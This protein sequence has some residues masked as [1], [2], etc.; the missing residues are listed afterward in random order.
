METGLVTVGSGAGAVALANL[1]QY[2]TDAAGAYSAA[3][4]RALAKGSA[5][6]TSWCQENGRAFLPAPPGTVVAYLEAAAERYATATVELYAWAIGRLHEAAG[7]ENPCKAERVR[8]RLRAIRRAKGTRGRQAVG[9][10]RGHIDRMLDAAGSDL[11]GLRDRALLA[12]AYDTL[13]RRSELAALDVAD[14]EAGADGTG[15]IIVRRSKTDQTGAGSVRFLAADTVEHVNRYLEAAGLTEGA[16]F[17]SVRKG[18]RIGGRLDGGD[19]ARIFRRA[20]SA[21]GLDVQPSGHSTRVGP[22]QDMMAAGCELAAVMLAGGW[23]SP[24]MVAR[25][26]ERLNV[27]RGAMARLAVAQGRA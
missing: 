26:T 21:A 13:C 18:G 25:Y 3:T 2:S 12:V 5:A 4:E 23:R 10:N 16:L 17:R 8:L 9:L 14:L 6:F 1:E 15:S 7:L 22:A 27:R 11:R 19:V 24:S 20:A